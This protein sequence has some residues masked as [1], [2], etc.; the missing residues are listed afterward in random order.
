MLIL[1]CYLLA[2]F[3]VQI[4]IWFC[5]RDLLCLIL[6]FITFPIAYFSIYYCKIVVGIL[7]FII[8]ILISMVLCIF[9]GTG[10]MIGIAN[11]FSSVF[12]S[13]IMIYDYNRI[14]K[15]KNY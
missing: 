8:N 1:G 11:L 6:Y 13:F 10:N 14:V 5:L 15:Y 9:T 2:A 7:L 12:V 4:L 3:I